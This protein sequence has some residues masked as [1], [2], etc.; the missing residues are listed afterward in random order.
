MEKH[1]VVYCLTDGEQSYIG[2]TFN[3]SVRKKQHKFTE[4]L[5][6]ILKNK[7][8][9]YDIMREGEFTKRELLDAEN[10][11]IQNN[12]CINKYKPLT[13]FKNK[14]HKYMLKWGKQYV[15]CESCDCEV[16]RWNW[17]KHVQ[18]LKHKLHAGDDDKAI[19]KGG[20]MTYMRAVSI[21]NKQKKE[22]DDS[23][24]HIIPT[25]GS[26]EQNEVLEIFQQHI[27]E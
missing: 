24:V 14:Q 13:N 1:G 21:Y 18:S 22:A 20:K 6:N 12:E 2:S 9:R 8:H 25:K 17:C 15:H 23:H 5:Q 19:F 11:C 16:T 26:P 7:N 10:E 4:Y 3:L 27:L